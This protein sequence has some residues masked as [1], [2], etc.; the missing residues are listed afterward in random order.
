MYEYGGLHSSTA[1]C[2]VI[3]FSLL[4]AILTW[5]FITTRIADPLIMMC[6]FLVIAILWAMLITAYPVFR[7]WKHNTFE[8]IHRFG[9]WAV[10]GIFWP[11]LWLF[12][13]ALKH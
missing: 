12:T 2:S 6:T 13:R 3:W 4:S 11:E 7:S 1:F 8:I 9:G 10:L 5:E